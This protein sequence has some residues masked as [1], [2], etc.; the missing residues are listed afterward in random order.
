M[1]L[2]T[3][4]NPH[5][6]DGLARNGNCYKFK[7]RPRAFCRAS[8]WPF[9]VSNGMLEI[10]PNDDLD[11]DQWEKH[12]WLLSMRAR[13]VKRE[14]ITIRTAVPDTSSDSKRQPLYCRISTGHH[15]FR[16]RRDTFYW[17]PYFSSHGEPGF[18][19][20]N[21]LDAVTAL[22]GFECRIWAY[23]VER[24]SMEVY[25]RF[26]VSDMNI[27][28]ST[29]YPRLHGAADYFVEK[30]SAARYTLHQYNSFGHLLLSH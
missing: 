17:M 30:N 24:L 6:I 21:L 1:D 8:Y 15:S 16:S 26:S 28:I 7:E 25:L 14:A 19:P 4:L 11:L 29:G 18:N 10:L 27:D 13:N 22:L 12:Y 5:R 20:S 9:S 3:L 23:T 2:E